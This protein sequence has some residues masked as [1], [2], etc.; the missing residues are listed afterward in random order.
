MNRSGIGFSS[1]SSPSNRG[2]GRGGMGFRGRGRGGHKA[3]SPLLLPPLNR[4]FI[5]RASPPIPT[6]IDRDYLERTG[7]RITPL[8]E[9]AAFALIHFSSDSENSNHK[10]S[11]PT[12][13]SSSS[14]TTNDNNAVIK[15]FISI[16]F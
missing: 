7:P 13:S 16:L 9:S 11:N 4:L 12:L 14:S 1:S 8:T 5:C 2:G 3:A 10:E 6:Q 15:L